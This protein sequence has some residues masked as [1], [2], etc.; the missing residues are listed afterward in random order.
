[1]QTG[2]ELDASP[3]PFKTFF[4]TVLLLSAVGF[5]ATDLYLPSL[6]SIRDAFESTTRLAQ[7]TLSFYLFAFSLSQLFYGPFSD[8]FGRRKVAMTG[9]LFSFIGTFVCI[10]AWDMQVLLIGRVLQGAALGVGAA[11][12]RAAMRDV[13]SGD[14]LAHV[15]SFLP[16]GTAALLAGAPALG[17]YVQ[18]Y[19]GWRVNFMFLLL[20]TILVVFMIF[21]W[22]PETNRKLNP[23]ALKPTIFLKNYFHLLKSPIFLGYVACASLSFGGLFAYFATSPFLFEEVLGLTP[24]QY[25]W[26]AFVVASGIAL[27]GFGNSILVKRF[28]RHRMLVA[29]VVTMFCAGL[30]MLIPAL[31]GLISVSLIVFPMCLYGVGLAASFANAFAGALHSFAKIAGF[32]GGLYGCIQ[33][34]GGSLSTTLVAFFKA[35]SQLPLSIILCVIGVLCYFLQLIA[36]KSFL[37]TP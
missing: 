4:P 12:A 19:L 34:L 31:F 17:G 32:A 6:P 2:R 27:G 8:R 30:I 23:S 28:G 15:G 3:P 5:V 24:V 16:V 21:R 14:K 33:I 36:F 35:E 11:I 29:S 37:R 13:Y 26:L 9:I 25:G 7:F 10:L 20:I 1:M 18:T 22:L